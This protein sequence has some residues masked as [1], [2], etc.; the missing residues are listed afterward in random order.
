M[1]VKK[2]MLKFVV[3]VKSARGL[4]M[5]KSDHNFVSCKIKLVVPW[6]ERKEIR[7]KVGKIKSKNYVNVF[8]K[9][10]I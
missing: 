2:M 5:G 9:E 8:K 1:L 10:S 6:M 3:N 4:Q 7:K